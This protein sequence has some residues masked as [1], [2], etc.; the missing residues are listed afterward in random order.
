LGIVIIGHRQTLPQ[1]AV[2]ALT[3]RLA[4]WLPGWAGVCSAAI[5]RGATHIGRGHG[6]GRIGKESR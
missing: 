3:E 4:R 1:M 5:K 2:P 6:F